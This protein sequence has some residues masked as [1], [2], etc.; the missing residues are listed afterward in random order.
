MLVSMFRQAWEGYCR[1]R[2]F[3]E[4][5]YATQTGF[6]V[7]QGQLPLGRMVSWGS[8]S[9]PRRTVLRNIAA[10]KIWSYG[11]SATPNFWPYPHFKLKA[12]VLFATVGAES[13][14]GPVLADAR[15]QHQARRTVCKGW[16]NPRWH[17]L[18]MAYLK[19]LGGA[20]AKT[21]RLP[22]SESES[23]SLDAEPTQFVSPV[24]TKT[25]RQMAEDGE[26]SDLTTLGT[27]FVEVD[28]E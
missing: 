19:L 2:G 22:L 11:V 27:V 20:D 12:R 4:Y 14:P 1:G 7:S 24:S 13:E 21:V 6:H 16:R 5:A 17:G 25:V 28:P 15:K 9:R 10:G 3:D 23:L 8:G 26:E 18:L